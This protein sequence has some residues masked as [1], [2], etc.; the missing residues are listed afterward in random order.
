[1]NKESGITAV[2]PATAFPQKT[3]PFV[4]FI[5]IYSTH[6]PSVCYKHVFAHY[7]WVRFA[8]PHVLRPSSSAIALATADRPSSV[9]SPQPRRRRIVKELGRLY[10][11][12]RA[13]SS[14]IINLR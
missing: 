14:K 5:L 1:M 7:K 11:C 8:E 2:M 4:M 6:C 12:Q 9:L 3:N 13:V 10:T